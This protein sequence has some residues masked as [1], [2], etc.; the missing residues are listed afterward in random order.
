MNAKRTHRKVQRSPAEKAR[1]RHLR[2]HF[3]ST[4]PT[5]EELLTSGDVDEFITLGEYLELRDAV[6]ALKQ[7]RKRKGLSLAAVAERSQMDKAAISRLENGLQ[8]NP[9][10]S[11]LYR[12]AAAIDAQLTWTVRSAS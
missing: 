9:T 4:R 1:L 12:Y 8:T 3:Q 10:V 2:E 6:R 5:P 11:T 7:E